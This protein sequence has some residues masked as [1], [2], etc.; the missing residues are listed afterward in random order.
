MAKRKTKIITRY[1]QIE[2]G[3][4]YEFQIKLVEIWY[5][6]SNGIKED[7][8]SLEFH[9]LDTES[10]ADPRESEDFDIWINDLI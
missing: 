5:L 8:E 10:N 2:P 3:M 4:T 7:R 9:F 1:F 6:N